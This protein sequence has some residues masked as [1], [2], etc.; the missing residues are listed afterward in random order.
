MAASG[1][2]VWRVD[3][4][5]DAR[6]TRVQAIGGAVAVVVGVYMTNFYGPS[7]SGR[8]SSGAISVRDSV[9]EFNRNRV[10]N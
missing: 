8:V 1:S 6:V 4:S 3:R 5:L 2:D 7:S 9:V 10:T